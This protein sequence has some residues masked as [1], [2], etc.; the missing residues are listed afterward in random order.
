MLEAKKHAKQKSN[1]NAVEHH[2]FEVHGCSI[3]DGEPRAGRVFL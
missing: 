2:L 3:P 1:S